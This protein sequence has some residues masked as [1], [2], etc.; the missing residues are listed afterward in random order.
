[1]KQDRSTIKSPTGPLHSMANPAKK[2]DK[3]LSNS[4]SLQKWKHDIEFTL[5]IGS[6]LG[7]DFLK[8]IQLTPGLPVHP[9]ALDVTL[10]LPWHRH[11]RHVRHRSGSLC[12]QCE[13]GF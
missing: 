7:P 6:H 5:Q 8:Y 3:K 4:V 12:L 2:L 11:R 1:M 10:P 13:C 9:D